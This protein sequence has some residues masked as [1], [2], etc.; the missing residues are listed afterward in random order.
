MS[1]FVHAQ[2]MKNCSRRGGGQNG[3]ILSTQLL[4]DPFVSKKSQCHIFK[5]VI[6]SK[7][8]VDVMTHIIRDNAAKRI[9]Q[10][11]ELF[12]YKKYEFIF[13]YFSSSHTLSKATIYILFL[14]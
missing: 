8:F 7:F 9:K 10:F 14:M 11:F 13:V 2:G 6:F 12:I 4:N 3:K 5:M 1:V